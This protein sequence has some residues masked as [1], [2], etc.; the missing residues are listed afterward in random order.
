MRERTKR[1]TAEL[2]PTYDR[3]KYEDASVSAIFTF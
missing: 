1:D 2:I 3:G